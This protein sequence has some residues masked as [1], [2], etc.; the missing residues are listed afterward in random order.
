LNSFPS[1]STGYTKEGHLESLQK[2]K[3]DIK[4]TITKWLYHLFFPVHLFDP[5]F[6]SFMGHP[7]TPPGWSVKGRRP[8]RPS[9]ALGDSR[10][11]KVAL[12][13]GH[14]SICT[15]SSRCSVQSHLPP[16]HACPS[17]QGALLPGGQWTGRSGLAQ[18]GGRQGSRQAMGVTRPTRKRP[19]QKTKQISPF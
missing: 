17:N 14:A 8:T 16:L 18:E 19:Q 7:G 3:Q 5:L 9:S 4:R 1:L 10:G 12:V 13:Q 11:D 6:L 15:V 2:Q